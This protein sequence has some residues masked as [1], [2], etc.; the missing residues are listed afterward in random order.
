MTALFERALAEDWRDLHPAL[1]ERYGLEAAEG[2]EAVGEGEMLRLARNLLAYPVLWLGARDDFIFPEQGR[3]VPF[4]IQ[5][6]AFVD[7]AGNEALFLDRR[8]ATE[9]ERRFVD[10]LRW[11]PERDCITDFYG[12]HGVVASDLH[13]RAEDG[14]LRLSL[15]RQWLR[16]GG[17]YLPVPGL[18]GA[19]GRLV[20][21]YDDDA[22]RYHVEAAIGNPLLGDVFVY[23]GYFQNG[24]EDAPAERADPT[25]T[26]SRLGDVRLPD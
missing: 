10:T 8:F 3:D 2:R 23:E 26:S 4:R 17:R 22:E 16:F 12:H 20:D 1:R 11:N 13:L 21:G 24:F 15:G 5:T 6:E 7:G 18:L 14:D 25:A 19:G 9:P